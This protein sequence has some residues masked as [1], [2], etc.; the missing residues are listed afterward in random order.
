[1]TIAS[2]DIGL[3]RIGLAITYDEKIVL[4]LK[5]IIRKNRN[6]AAN[7]ISLIL[8]E[9]D[10]KKIIVGLPKGGNSEEE[11]K[12]RIEHFVNLLDFEGDIEYQDEFGSSQEAKE[13]LKGDVKIKR[14]GRIDSL[15][16]MLILKRWLN[17]PI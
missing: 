16:A 4:P 2:L 1:M 17:L 12:R 7:E 5:A 14:D 11:M 8:K 15:S 13:L 10:A 9:K 6:Q 3:K